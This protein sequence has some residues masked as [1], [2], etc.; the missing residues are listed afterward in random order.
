MHELPAVVRSPAKDVAAGPP[1]TTIVLPD[2]L[3][4]V[5]P[6]G[7]LAPFHVTSYDWLARV[8]LKAPS[9]SACMEYK[10]DFKK[11]VNKRASFIQNLQTVQI[12][13]KMCPISRII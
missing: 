5:A 11:F 1:P 3:P 6:G 2:A 9:I 4:G 10:Q 12:I 7:G 13:A 8:L